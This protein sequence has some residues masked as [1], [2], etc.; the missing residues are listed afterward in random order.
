MLQRH[1]TTSEAGL[2]GHFNQKG[3]VT[4][5]ATHLQVHAV[6]QS[7]FLHHLAAL[8]QGQALQPLRI[9]QRH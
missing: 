5:Q 2:K 3:H 9:L 8:V 7:P 4:V 1:Q 6:P